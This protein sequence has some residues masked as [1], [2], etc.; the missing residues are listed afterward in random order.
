MRVVFIIYAVLVAAIFVATLV[1]YIVNHV[2]GDDSS[3]EGK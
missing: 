1:Y 2:K 3:N